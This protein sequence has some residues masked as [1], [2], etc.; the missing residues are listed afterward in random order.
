MTMIFRLRVGVNAHEVIVLDCCRNATVAHSLN[1]R[2]LG[3]PAPAI[4]VLPM[5]LVL[6]GLIRLV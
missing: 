6:F 5:L 3:E 4:A 2:K 1:R